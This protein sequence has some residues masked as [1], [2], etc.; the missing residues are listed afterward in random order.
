VKNLDKEITSIRRTVTEIEHRIFEQD[1]HAEARE[2]I[3][4]IQRKTIDNCK[5]QITDIRLE[6][7]MFSEEATKITDLL[8]GCIPLSLTDEQKKEF[9]ERLQW[10]FVT[11]LRGKLPGAFGPRAQR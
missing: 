9:H 1:S 5:R 6:R 11:T 10:R 3:I 2:E 8:V 7:D 4:E